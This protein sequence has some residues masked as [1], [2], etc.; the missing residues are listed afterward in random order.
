MDKLY[1]S[2]KKRSI[3]FIVSLCLLTTAGAVGQCLQDLTD[4]QPF[5][6]TTSGAVGGYPGTK[7]FDNS[8]QAFSGWKQNTNPSATASAWIRINFTTAQVVKGYSVSAI[9]DN[10][11]NNNIAPANWQLQASN[12]GVSWTK[13]DTRTGEVF[14]G[15][16]Q[17]HIYPIPNTT[18][19]KYYRILISET[20]LT[21][22]AMVGIGEMQLFA[23][24]CLVGTVFN[25]NG[26][27]A[28]AY[29]PGVD[30]PLAGV[31]VSIVTSP[32]GNVVASTTTDATGA[33]SFSATDVPASGNFSVM[34]RP[35]AG[36]IFVTRPANLWS[37]WVSMPSPE[38]EPPTGSVFFGYHIAPSTGK[39][40]AV[41]RMLLK[42][43]NLDFGLQDAQPPAP[44]VC[45]GAPA[46]I[47][48][49]HEGSNGTF[50]VSANSWET[51][52][53]QQE[54]FMYSTNILY[55]SL[56]AAVTDYTFGNAPTGSINGNR[57]VLLAEQRY[58][59]CSFLGTISD[60]GYAP[61][62]NQLLNNVSGGWRKTYGITTGDAYDRILAV[63]GATVGSL[64]FF[65]QTGLSLAAGGTYT[66][67]FYGKHANSYAQ[68]SGGGVQDAQLIVEVLDNG[69]SLVSSGSLNL[70]AP[71][72]YIADRP[73]APWE[74]RM[75]TF[76][77][78]AGTGPFTVQ[79]RAST[80]AVYGN[81]FYIDNVVLSPCALV[82]LPISLNNFTARPTKNNDILLSWNLN[83]PSPAKA[84][85]EYSTDGQLFNV[86]G[87]DSLE[88]DISDY[89]YMHLQPGMRVN[90]Y[91][92]RMVDAQGL[93]TYSSTV[94]ADLGNVSS[95]PVL[96]YPNPATDHVF[97]QTSVTIASMQLID[98]TGKMV[99]GNADANTTLL[100]ID[101]KGL[102]PG[103]YYARLNSRQEVSMYKIIISR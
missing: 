86:L 46:T 62:T 68:V 13:I 82:L 19:Y 67:A 14:T 101:L 32:A 51:A 22:S 24:V 74:L 72:S 66:L 30:A 56:P 78:P 10:S 28:S 70:T 85:I 47:N 35:P 41:N 54:G 36:K 95:S 93:I 42:G 79:L 53:P 37:T 63:N 90:Y 3:L 20:F 94:R 71:A 57:G 65:K 59:I 61:Y 21:T 69:N 52:H 80:T 76:T 43:G 45:V 7:A 18:A 99:R 8:D 102:P 84:T 49:I 73:E 97:I 12:D 44:F 6:I 39:E 96:I 29:S 2:V 16:G 34:V 17:T 58:A 15:K 87:V 33:Y 50:G 11:G 100:K 91:R 55:S 48:M 5:T 89:S 88:P 98:A 92:L 103:I 38:E 26:D 77:A 64:P 4:T 75:F 40:A 25:D 83:T 9:D 27:R 23:D 1:F 31:P 60:L 81:D